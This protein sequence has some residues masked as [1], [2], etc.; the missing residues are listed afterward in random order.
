MIEAWIKKMP[1]GFWD[2]N[3][4]NQK[5]PLFSVPFLHLSPNPRVSVIFARISIPWKSFNQKYGFWA[6]TE[7]IEMSL[8]QILLIFFKTFVV[9]SFNICF[10]WTQVRSLS[11]FVTNW[12]TDQLTCSCCW[13][14]TDATVADE[15]D[16]SV[17]FGAEYQHLHDATGSEQT[18]PDIAWFP[19]TLLFPSQ[20]VTL[21]K[22]D[23]TYLTKPDL[24]NQIYWTKPNN[25]SDQT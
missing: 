7:E 21:S 17:I 6:C 3:Q 15:D 18:E 1:N 13:D 8:I 11:T 9:F 14:L 23:P 5:G 12:L 16:Y 2:W 25:Q 4:N 20:M 22:P 10:D 24:P 19:K